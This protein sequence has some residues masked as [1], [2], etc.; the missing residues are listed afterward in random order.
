MCYMFEIYALKV[1]SA[2]EIIFPTVLIEPISQTLH[3]IFL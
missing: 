1:K 2:Q 3:L